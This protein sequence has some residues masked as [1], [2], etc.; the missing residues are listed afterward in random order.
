M[1][2][3]LIKVFETAVMRTFSEVILVELTL[4][5]GNKNGDTTYDISGIAGFLGDTVCSVALR[6]SESTAGKMRDRLVSER[7]IQSENILDAVCECVSMVA[8]NAITAFHDKKIHLSTP[9]T[10]RGKDHEIDFRGYKE[11]A[12]LHFS[13]EIGAV[14]VVVAYGSDSDHK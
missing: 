10:I 12:E 13:S 5:N 6:I 14:C 11:K 3:K 7:I 8:G 2:K 9:Q 4:V 1:K